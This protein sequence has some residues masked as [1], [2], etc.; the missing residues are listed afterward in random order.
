[1]P[2]GYERL[3]LPAH[4]QLK[5]FEELV[6]AARVPAAEGHRRQVAAFEGE[7]VAQQADRDDGRHVVRNV[8][9][10]GRS[11]QP[12]LVQYPA[13]IG[14]PHDQSDAGGKGA[15]GPLREDDQFRTG[16]L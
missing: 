8:D 15:E 10:G 14:P 6:P 1:M 5:R 9:F 12:R 13:S 11:Q 2:R 4:S 16:W 3:A 7:R